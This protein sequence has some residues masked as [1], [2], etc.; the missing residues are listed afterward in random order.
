MYVYALKYFYCVDFSMVKVS[1]IFAYR[2]IINGVKVSM[3]HA[4]LWPVVH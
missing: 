4:H 1:K 2:V 3:N